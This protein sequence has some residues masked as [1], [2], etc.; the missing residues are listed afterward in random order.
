MKMK[1]LGMRHSYGEFTPEGQNSPIKYDKYYV[2]AVDLR[3]SKSIDQV[4]FTT[5]MLEFKNG[6]DF[7]NMINNYPMVDIVNHTWDF[8]YDDRGNVVNISLVK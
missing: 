4:G 7:M 6:K 2:W 8:E 1:V 5:K 3:E